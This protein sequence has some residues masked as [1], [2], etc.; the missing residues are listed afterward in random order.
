VTNIVQIL[1][2]KLRDEETHTH[3]SQAPSNSNPDRVI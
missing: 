2:H 3:R 1:P